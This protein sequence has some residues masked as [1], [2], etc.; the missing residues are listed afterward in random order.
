MADG[1]L[2]T[3][4]VNWM[5]LLQQDLVKQQQQ[6]LLPGPA[7]H[8]VH[9]QQQQQGPHAM[10]WPVDRVWVALKTLIDVMAPEALMQLPPELFGLP[11]IILQT[12]VRHLTAVVS[13]ADAAAGAGGGSGGNVGR[14]AAGGSRG[15]LVHILSCL[16]LLLQKMEAVFWRMVQLSHSA[17]GSLSS[18]TVSVGLGHGLMHVPPGPAA[19]VGAA[20]AAVISPLELQGLVKRCCWCLVGQNELMLLKGLVGVCGGLLLSRMPAWGQPGVM[21]GEILPLLQHMVLTVPGSKMVHKMV[22][23]LSLEVRVRTG[24]VEINQ[25]GH[26]G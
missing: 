20:G 1:G 15:S 14:L 5:L 8:A 22:R 23:G 19:A 25:C 10:V 13:Q 4:L 21:G 18:P 26:S 24:D 9:Q 16:E 3:L 12:A 2:K 17:A 11:A 7:Q 6:Q